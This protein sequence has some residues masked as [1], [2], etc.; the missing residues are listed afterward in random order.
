M[1]WT[2][3]YAMNDRGRGVSVDRVKASRVGVPSSFCAGMKTTWSDCGFCDHGCCI[4]CASCVVVIS[5][6]I[7]CG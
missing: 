4:S 3:A 1:T 2:T 7:G 5:S 6:S